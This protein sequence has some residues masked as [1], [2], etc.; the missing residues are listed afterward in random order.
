MRLT[1]RSL[2]ATTLSAFAAPATA[3]PR[4]YALNGENSEVSFRFNLNGITQS[5]TLP[6]RTADIQ[7]DPDDLEASQARVTADIRRAQTSLVFIT[8]A[9]L[10]EDVLDAENH[11]I[12]E[13]V[14]TDITLG[15]KGRLS[16]GATLTGLLTLRGVTRQIVFE[17][18]LSRPAGSTPDDL[19]VLYARLN[20]TISRSAFGANGYRDLVADAVDID[21][22]AELRASG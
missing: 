3:A 21:I 10:S 22:H 8:Q 20:G 9:L 7:L 13:F 6:V 12:V 15:A 1:R 2:L 16:E 18:R 14:S 17:V 19:S 5:G 11:P 4:T